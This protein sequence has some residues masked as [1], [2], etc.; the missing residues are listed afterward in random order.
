M[1]NKSII[2]Y[3]YNED[4][5]IVDNSR[6]LK[7]LK[8][9][10]VFNEKQKGYKYKCL[11][12]G[13]EDIISEYNLNRKQGCN[14]C[15]IPSKKILIGYNDIWTT[16]PLLASLFVDV[17]DG[18][19]H[20]ENSNKKTNFKCPNCGNIIKNIRIYTVCRRGLACRK[21]D[22]K[23]S[24]A[25][26][27]MYNVL[28]QL[29]GDNFNSQKIF[30]WSKN[31]KYDFYIPNIKTIIET[32]GNQHYKE[33]FGR[34]GKKARNLEQEKNNDLKKKELALKNGIEENNYIIIDCRKSELEYIKNNVLNSKLAKLYD[35][36]K[37]EWNDVE[38]YALSNLVKRACELWNSGIES[39]I[40]IGKIMKMH[41]KTIRSY[42]KKGSIINW[43]N[44]DVKVSKEKAIKKGGKVG[45][46]VICLN[47]KKI[48]NNINEACNFYHIKS[49]HIGSCCRGKRKYCGL[50]F[51]TGEKLK[52]MYYDE[53]IKMKKDKDIE[54]K[55][56]I[57][58]EFILNTLNE[59]NYEAYIVGGSVRDSL[60]KK[61]PKDWDFTTNALP[62]DIKKIFSKIGYKILEIGTKHGTICVY[63]DNKIYEITTFRING[64]YKDNRSPEEVYFTNSLKEDVSRRDFT[65]NSICIDVNRNVYD[66]FGGIKDIENKIIRAVGKAEDRYNDDS[67]RMIR[68]IRF[69]C[70]HNFVIEE[71]TL[72][73]I[74]R[75]AYLI[76]M[77][78]KERIRDELCKI[79][80][81][82][83][84]GYGV[85][86]LERTGLLQYIIPELCECVGFEQYNIHH[87]KDV[88][89]HTLAVLDNTPKIL[90]V[91]LG[92]L[93]HDIAKPKSFSIDD[94]RVGHFIGHH[95]EG[96]KAT[97]DILTRLKFDNKTIN[98]VK[99]LV[100]CHMDRYDKIRTTNIKKF[101][102][103]VGM[104]NLN[105]L[106][107]LQIAD[108][109]GSAKEYQDFSNV[110]NLKEQCYKIINEKQPLTVKD[111][112][113]NG[114][115][116]IY[117]GFKQGKEIGIA[118]NSLLEMVLE[119]TEL[120]NKEILLKMVKRE[121][122]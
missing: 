82:D 44:Y 107:E 45:K 85:K 21:C 4:D 80:I 18:Y 68:A 71:N 48:F 106:F 33:E 104:D 73:A 25:E 26:K 66:Y 7:I 36:S 109:L 32:H 84:P 81:S 78:S 72:Q 15:C 77:I 31:K 102:N 57:E 42:L 70:Q 3:K 88:F 23:I 27:F 108:I 5:I 86:M 34:M 105:N 120:N 97:E 89:E 112:A 2:K 41:Y 111:L 76:Q 74:I 17:K 115:D 62:N 6:N 69:S 67:L 122:F 61:I 53:Y 79:L 83:Y 60:L 22:D 100:R 52:W 58:I 11:K 35:L 39:T 24:Y 101:I 37:I 12:C 20:T 116:L 93:L 19:K 43:C 47:N 98:T 75:N 91:R 50:D 103:R 30:E 65:I 63:N 95:I 51:K 118:L 10:K 96:E 40:E 90:E 1:Y 16:N 117:L 14:V 9:I 38:K 99:I 56:P 59:N 49:N 55:L 46:K 13:N 121:I 119:N 54:I 114:N 94:N 64:I 110:V 113:I 29:L 8:Q 92:A 28:E 87:D